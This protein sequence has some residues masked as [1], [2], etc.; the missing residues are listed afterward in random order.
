MFLDEAQDVLEA[1]QEH[2]ECYT[3]SEVLN[4]HTELLS[5]LL[6]EISVDAYLKGLDRGIVEQLIDLISFEEVDLQ[7]EHI[8]DDLMQGIEQEKC[9]AFF[10]TNH[11]DILVYTRSIEKTPLTNEL[12]QI[13]FFRTLP[14]LEGTGIT[15]FQC[16]STYYRNYENSPFYGLICEA[17]T[18]MMARQVAAMYVNMLV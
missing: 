3:S 4:E 10:K 13:Q 11:K 8:L 7:S 17:V 9:I 6:D 14:E 15:H 5:E 16:A 18:K 12:Y 1:T 2:F